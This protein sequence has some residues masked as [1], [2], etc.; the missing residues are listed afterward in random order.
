M[1]NK[2]LILLLSILIVLMN[3]CSEKVTNSVTFKNMASGTIYVNFLG[4]I[5]TIG[6]G[7]SQTIRDIPKGNYSYQTS[8]DVPANVTGSSSEGATKATV[9]IKAS[10][11]ISVLY[12]SV[13]QGTGTQLNYVL[14][15]TISSSDKVTITSDGDGG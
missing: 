9:E 5:F 10:T 11:K 2:I 15:A 8:F 14:I 12:T 13:L 7:Q 6:S 1:K 4:E 3:G